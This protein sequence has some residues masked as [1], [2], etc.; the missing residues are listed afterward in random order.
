MMNNPPTD[1]RFPAEWESDGMILIAW[2]HES[3]DWAYMLPDVWKCY[4]D[5]VSAIS[6]YQKVAIV[7][8]NVDAA[9]SRLSAFDPTRVFF[10]ELPTN[11]T[12]T[13]DYGPLTILDSTSN[14]VCLDY[15]FNGWGMKF[16]ACFDNLVSCKLKKIGLLTAPLFNRRDFVLEGGGIESDGRGSIMT[17]SLCQLSPNRNST[18][19]REE[20]SSRLLLDFGAQQILWVDHGYLVGDDTDSHIDT[21]ARFAPG[22]A[23]VYV[24]CQNP[25]DEH[26]PELQAMKEDLQSFRTLSGVPFN[27]IELPLPDPIFDEDG[28]RLP[29]TYANFLALPQAIIMPTYRQSRNDE[30]TRQILT[31]AYERPVICVDCTALIRQHGSLHCA[32]MQIPQNAIAL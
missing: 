11:D 4:C 32:T 15:C 26:Y 31:V 27:L 10:I 6:P 22:D 24:G 29:A 25:S 1:V 19:S 18:L 20:I 13:R 28:Q 30:L 5:M 17:T 21:L 16:A 12:W 7:A 9:K 23:I 14:P 2:P 3:T 8:P